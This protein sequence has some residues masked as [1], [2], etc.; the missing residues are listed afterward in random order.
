MKEEVGIYSP[1]VCSHTA[2][3]R[4][5]CIIAHTRTHT[6]FPSSFLSGSLVIPA[7]AGMTMSWVE[8]ER[9]CEWVWVTPFT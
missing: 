1:A 8:R 5:T 3:N 2:L 4:I 7:K 9:E 6:H